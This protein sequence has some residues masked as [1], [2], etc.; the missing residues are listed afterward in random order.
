MNPLIRCFHEMALANLGDPAGQ[1]LLVDSL[2]SED[3]SRRVFAANF[4]GEGRVVAAADRL[5]ALLDDPVADVRYR[6]AQSLL[7]LAQPALPGQV[8]NAP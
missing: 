2:T 4:A 7:M 5:T 6:A 1:T 8:D 3:P